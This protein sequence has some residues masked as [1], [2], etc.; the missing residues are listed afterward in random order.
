MV[1]QALR[2]AE[3]AYNK[4][5]TRN[6]FEII[7]SKRIKLKDFTS[8]DSLLGFYTV[9][10]RKQIIG[11]NENADPVQRLTG[12]I[13]ELG[14]SL[15]DYK[16]AA[17]GSRFG[18]Y[19]FFSLS[20]APAEFNANLAGADLCLDDDYI[21]ES[22]SYSDYE[23][24]LAYIRE[25]IGSCR[26][27][28]AKM[29]FEEEQMREFYEC[30]EGMPSFEQLASELKVD[31]GVVKFKFKALSYKNYELPN[32]PETRCDFLTNWRSTQQS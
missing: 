10:N 32:I 24:L 23:K 17:A 27:D 20:C 13:H 3:K 6:P 11:L 4:Y 16:L 18:D 14:H 22:I 30:H 29:Q 1:P 31:I 25:H 12:A 21:L 9:L 19:R 5:H 28:H 2:M 7:D 26:T 8:P 15:N